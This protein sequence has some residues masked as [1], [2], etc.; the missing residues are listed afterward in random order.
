MVFKVDEA[1]IDNMSE[2]DTIEF[3]AS[4]VDGELILT[5]VK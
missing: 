5:D 4:E 2:G 1:I 3:I